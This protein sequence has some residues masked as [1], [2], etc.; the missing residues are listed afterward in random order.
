MRDDTFVGPVAIVT[1]V[2]LAVLFLYPL[3][4]S[5]LKTLYSQE[6][7]P[8]E[9][10]E[11][12]V[13]AGVRDAQVLL[14]VLDNGSVLEMDL[15]TY[16]T[17][18]IRAEMPASFELEALKAQAVAARTYTLYKI[19]GGGNH[20]E[21]ADICTSPACCQAY[22]S[23]ERSRAGWG[24][25]ADEYETKVRRAV[26]ETDGQA[27]LYEGEPILAAFHSASAGRTRKSNAVWQKDLPYLQPVDSPEPAGSIPNYYSRVE[28]STEQVRAKILA[29]HPEADLSGSPENWLRDP[30]TD[31]AGTVE[32]LSVG[33]VRMK[34]NEVRSMLDLRSACFEWELRENRFIFSVTGYGHGVGLSQYGANQMAADG[35]GYAEII[36]HYYTGVSV[37]A[38]EAGER[39]T[40][41]P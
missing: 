21:T 14:K 38:W 19:G 13:P 2:L 5:F 26:T 25:R 16:L 8:V 3:R 15:G 6:E 27:A 33:G 18:V 32:S 24:R 20:G 12:L 4:G 23:E 30:E 39:F 37:G 22:S 11:L 10:E 1:A 9:T 41:L 7:Q 36:L 40:I 28:L 29:A 34:G 17:G 35:A 31:S